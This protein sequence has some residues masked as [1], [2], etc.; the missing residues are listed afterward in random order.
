M[1][2]KL[3]PHKAIVNIKTEVYEVTSSGK[4]SGRPDKKDS[5]LII[6]DGKDLNEINLKLNQ[7]M[8]KFDEAI[9][10][11]ESLSER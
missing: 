4:C 2:N 8:E 10:N 6:I 5:K 1:K 3:A 9:K 11:T 7:L